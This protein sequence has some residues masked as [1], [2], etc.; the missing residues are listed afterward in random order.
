MDEAA[1]HVHL[2]TIGVHTLLCVFFALLTAG[3]NACAAV[4][5]RKAAAQVPTDRSMHVSLISDLIKRR[6]TLD[7][8]HYAWENGFDPTYCEAATRYSVR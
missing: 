7:R 8:A 5:Q 3:S 6:V 1:L 4:L 2:H